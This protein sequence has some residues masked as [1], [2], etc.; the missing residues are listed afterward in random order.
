MKHTPGPWGYEQTTLTI[1]RL[2]VSTEDVKALNITPKADPNH[3]IA[4]VPNDVTPKEQEANARLIAAAPELLEAL[5]EILAR[6][7]FNQGG[8]RDARA[9]I[10]KAEGLQ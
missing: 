5:K 7:G 9:A 6:A 3:T 4:Y 1:C 8:W 10:A 2:I